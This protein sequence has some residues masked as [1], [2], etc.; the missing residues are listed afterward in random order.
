MLGVLG[1]GGGLQGGYRCT[2][3]WDRGYMGAGLFSLKDVMQSHLAKGLVV[4]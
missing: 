3:L 1:D 4:E 2:A